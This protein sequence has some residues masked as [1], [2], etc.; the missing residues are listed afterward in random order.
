M[1]ALFWPTLFLTFRPI[2]IIHP[3][4]NRQIKESITAFENEIM[5]AS[6]RG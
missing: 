3:S 2:S 6:N 5:M 1:T 4:A